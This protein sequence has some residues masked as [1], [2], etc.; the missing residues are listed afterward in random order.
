MQLYILL[1]EHDLP[2]MRDCSGSNG[3]I[4]LWIFPRSLINFCSREY[5]L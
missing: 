3:G 1:H 4:F 2:E 5:R